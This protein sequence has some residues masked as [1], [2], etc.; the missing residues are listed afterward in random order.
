MK[1]NFQPVFPS[2]FPDW[3]FT[4]FAGVRAL[5]SGG[6]NRF[7]P[8]C[9]LVLPITAIPFYCSKLNSIYDNA[10]YRE[11]RL[12][13]DELV[14]FYILSIALCESLPYGM[15]HFSVIR[16]HHGYIYMPILRELKW[17]NKSYIYM[18]PILSFFTPIQM[19]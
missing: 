17:C 1:S 7:N 19:A 13:I 3:F 10:P 18:Q 2:Q 15:S 5:L 16:Y 6:G 11:D 14:Q 8:H 9:S 12:R 4:S